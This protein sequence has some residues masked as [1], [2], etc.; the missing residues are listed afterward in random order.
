MAKGP[1]RG[2]GQIAQS[3]RHGGEVVSRSTRELSRLI[4][5]SGGPGAAAIVDPAFQLAVNA[6][7]SASEI[8]AQVAEAAE[9]H[10]GK[11][12]RRDATSDAYLVWLQIAAL[13]A[14]GVAAGG[15]E[16]IRIAASAALSM[17]EDKRSVKASVIGVLEGGILISQASQDA[18]EWCQSLS[19]VPS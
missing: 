2:L 7:R 18:N 11:S 16:A 8:V 9:G 10:R 19:S 15:V 13:T 4:E 12:V 17:V 1:A 3:A 14:S 5:V 6:A